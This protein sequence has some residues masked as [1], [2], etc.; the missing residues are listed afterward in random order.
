MAKVDRACSCP[1]DISAN[2]NN[3]ISVNG[4]KKVLEELA[5]Q[6]LI[7]RKEWGKQ[8]MY[9]PLQVRHLYRLCAGWGVRGAGKLADTCW[10]RSLR[11]RAGRLKR[12]KKRMRR[13]R[14]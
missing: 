1:A 4:A 13:R 12:R 9:G 7:M 10:E 2:L 3:T 5:D 11:R 6:E 14:G 8:K